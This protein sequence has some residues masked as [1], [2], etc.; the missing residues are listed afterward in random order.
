MEGAGGM[1]GEEGKQEDPV[2][3]RAA[4]SSAEAFP[5]ESGVVPAV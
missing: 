3:P 4:S 2:A 1:E 5:K